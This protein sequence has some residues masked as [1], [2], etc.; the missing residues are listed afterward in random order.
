MDRQCRKGQS[1][2]GGIFGGLGKPEA[3]F[4]RKCFVGGSTEIVL[5][6]FGC[7]ERRSVML[8]LLHYDPGNPS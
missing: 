1:E 6:D 2:D 8:T 4:R 7:R 5:V 3:W